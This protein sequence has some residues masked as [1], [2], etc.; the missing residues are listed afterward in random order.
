MKKNLAHIISFTLNPAILL[1]ISP[2]LVVYK[3]TKDPEISLWWTFVSSI[4]LFIYLAFVVIEVKRKKLINVDVSKR[5]QRGA[6][7]G[8][9]LILIVAYIS[10][11]I[12]LNA[13]VQLFIGVLAV[14]IGTLIFMFINRSIKASVHVGALTAF[15]LSIAI[16]YNGVFLTL[17]FLVPLMMWSRLH[18]KRH[19]MQEMLVGGSIASILI[20]VLYILLK[21]V[22]PHSF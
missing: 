1:L 16:L 13:P 15:I 8:A 3:V 14:M 17:L 21:V 19:T 12:L 18:L 22:A 6:V 2:F 10:T 11:V 5:S 4:F 9:A 7:Y 20:V